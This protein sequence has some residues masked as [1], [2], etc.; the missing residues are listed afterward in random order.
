VAKRKRKKQNQRPVT[1]DFQT[2]LNLPERLAVYLRAWWHISKA[3]WDF[4][5]DQLRNGQAYREYSKSKGK[6]KGRR[7][8]AAPCESLKYL[9][10]QILRRFL[11]FIPVHFVR[12]GNQVGA[13]IVTNAS[14]HAFHQYTY[15]VDIIN[16]FPSVQRS[17]IRANLVKPF[18]FGLRQFRGVEFDRDEIEIMLEATVDLVCLKDRLPQGAPTS[19]R[20]LDIVCFNMDADIWQAT[21]QQS[22]AIQQVSTTAYVDDITSSSNQEIPEEFRARIQEI[23]GKHRFIPHTSPDK[24]KYYS[25]QT[26]TVPVV[27][28]I[29]ITGDGQL[30]IAPRKVNQLRGRLNRLVCTEEWDA[31][32]LAEVNGLLGFI[33]QVHPDR[34]P[35]KLR[36]VVANAETRREALKAKAPVTILVEAKEDEKAEAESTSPK[37]DQDSQPQDVLEVA[38][39]TLIQDSQFA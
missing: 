12:H 17:R 37:K 3:D 28:G 16:A 22:T 14:Q 9:Q 21:D 27:T 23:M 26:G 35:S 36:K 19:P 8:F 2:V 10:R 30:R 15:S 7:Y 20:I 11:A 18:K 31:K 33:R 39:K 6:G 5:L 24:N 29:I 38:G 25:P 32:I 13:S 4:C 34:L 1:P